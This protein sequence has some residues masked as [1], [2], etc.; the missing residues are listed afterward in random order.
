MVG[1]KYDGPF[2][3]LPAQQSDGGFPVDENNLGKSGAKWHQVID[4]GRDSRGN[5]NVVAGEGTGIVH[6][7]PGCGDID[8]KIGMSVG[9]PVIAPLKDDG[10][11]DEGFGE[12]TGLEAI[13]PKTAELVF[14]KLKAKGMLVSVEV[15]PHI[16]PHCWRTG[17]ELVFRLVDEW[18]INMDWRDEIKD[19]TRQIR[20]LPDS[21]D[22]QEREIE[23]LSNMGDWMISKKRFWGLALPIWVDE[24]TGDYEVIGSLAELKE[25]AVEGWNDF[26]GNTPHRPWIDK[27]KI[28]NPKT[29]N[30]MS[31]IPDVGNP[32]LDAGIVP[33]STMGYNHNREEWKKW[34]PAD[35]VTECFPGQFRNWFYSMLSLSTMMRYDEAD[36]AEDKKP[37]R[38]LLGH[39]LVQNEQGKPMHKSD[40]TAIWFEEAAEQLGVDTM[41]WMY[42]A[43][44]PAQDLRFGT[45]HPDKP[46]TLQT[47]EGPINKTKEGVPT[48]TVT[49]GPADETRRQILIPL[50]NCYKFFVDYAI[51]DG[52]VPS[53]DL[54][55]RAVVLHPMFLRPR[56]RRRWPAG[57]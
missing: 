27:V 13:S 15:Y 11:Y 22:G 38:T 16:Y 52:F 34:Y 5:A 17:D 8:H 48:A 39:R 2:D 47:P 9:M 28:R 50:W 24:Q 3:E 49:S 32:W 18:F 55:R 23:W 31:R 45:R 7:A 46:V 42:L 21:I 35:L 25:R 30:L 20:W 54:R 41:R 33:F 53:D 6:M 43:Q 12:F 14:E 57:R 40:G 1:W 4:G 36:N 19:V 29:G 26:E 10:T 51:A 56:Y 37:F 44:N